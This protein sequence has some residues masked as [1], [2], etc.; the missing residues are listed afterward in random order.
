VPIELPD[1]VPMHQLIPV[2]AEKVGFPDVV[3]NQHT[4]YQ[5]RVKSTDTIVDEH[6]TLS[7]VNIEANDILIITPITSSGG[8]ESMP[9]EDRR[10]SEDDTNPS[11][12]KHIRGD[13]HI[14]HD[15][16][17]FTEGSLHVR[18]D[19]YTHESIVKVPGVIKIHGSVFIAEDYNI[20]AFLNITGVIEINGSVFVGYDANQ[21]LPVFA[22]P[23]SGDLNPAD[24]DTISVRSGDARLIASGTAISFNNSPIELSIGSEPLRLVFEFSDEYFE[25]GIRVEEMDIQTIRFVFSR[26]RSLQHHKG[27]TYPVPLGRF[28]QKPMFLHYRIQDLENGDSAITYN[29]YVQNQ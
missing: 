11:T 17:L 3:D 15:T 21:P 1:D 22:E 19:V 25:K 18:G 5:V 29:V 20:N 16:D 4:P 28:E 6:E 13:V 2:L 23:N 26:H 24:Q 10:L 8:D 9:S 7:D 12:D 27:T 14:P